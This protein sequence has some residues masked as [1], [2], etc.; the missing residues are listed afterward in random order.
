MIPT[1][2]SFRYP[3]NA[4][5]GQHGSA[6][7]T[8]AF[9][10]IEAG[11]VDVQAQI[12]PGLPAFAIVGLADKA[13]KAREQVRA[14]L[15]ASGLAL[16][17]RRITVNLAPAD[18]SKGRQPLRPAD[19]ARADGGDRRD[20]ARCARWLHRPRRT[21]A[22]WPDRAGRGRVAGGDRRNARDEGLICPAACGRKRPGPA[23]TSRSLRRIR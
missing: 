13:V 10:G 17:A 23:R 3:S 12:A 4:E 20:S 21:R 9:Q 11:A 7:S 22:R 2:P 14:A 19:R 15:V 6:G 5:E 16:P 1:S 8:V 18:L